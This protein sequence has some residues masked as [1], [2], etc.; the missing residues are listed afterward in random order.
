MYMLFL[1][2][3]SV[4][5]ITLQPSGFGQNT[6]GQRQDVICSIDVPSDVD[7]GTVELGWLYEDDIITDDSRVTIYT[8]SDYYNGTTL[9]TII[10]F[11]PLTEEDEDEYICYAAINGS[12]L[13]EYISLQNIISKLFKACPVCCQTATH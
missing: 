2:L 5:N 10:Q 6:V 8:S 7:P 3:V 12:F 9:F 1:C 11:D 4:L 13:F